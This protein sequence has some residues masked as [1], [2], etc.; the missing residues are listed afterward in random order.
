M[1]HT[2]KDSLIILNSGII[3]K[4]FTHAIIVN[5]G[6]R[7][8]KGL[9]NLPSCVI[10]NRLSHSSLDVLGYTACYWIDFILKMHIPCEKLYSQHPQKNRSSTKEHTIG[11]DKQI[12]E[13]KIVN[14]FL[15]LSL[16]ICFGCSKE[17]LS[18]R[19]LFCYPQDNKICFG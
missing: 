3:L 12:F 19:Q 10:S 7:V 2:Q 5:G 4:T 11:Q 15:S 9:R 16:N 8:K 18:F 6:K 14:I 13:R 17:T 1:K